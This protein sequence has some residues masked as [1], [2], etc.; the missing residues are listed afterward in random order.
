M[1]FKK[2]KSGKLEKLVNQI[3]DKYRPD[4]KCLNFLCVWRYKE[5]I[6]DGRLVLAEVFKLSNKNRDVFDYDVLLEVDQNAFKSSSAEERKQLIFHELEHVVVEYQVDKDVDKG[7]GDKRSKK[8]SRSSDERSVKTRGKRS[9]EITEEDI[10][11]EESSHPENTKKGKKKPVKFGLSAQEV[12]EHIL[13]S[14]DSV[15]IGEPV[16][17]KNDRIVFSIRPH[18]IILQS[19]RFFCSTF[20]SEI[21]NFGVPEELEGLRLFLNYAKKQV[22]IAETRGTSEQVD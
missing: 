1:Q 5:K 16:R 20:F 15:P 14:L 18:D 2:D 17:D 22:G 8:K 11:I 21:M 10:E 4:L 3:I 19:S 12:Y 13:Q 7:K 6:T 9:R